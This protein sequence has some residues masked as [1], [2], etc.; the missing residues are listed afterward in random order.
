MH[1]YPRYDIIIKGKRN[2]EIIQRIA[3]SNKSIFRTLVRNVINFVICI[4]F[5]CKITTL[6]LISKLYFSF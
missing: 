1:E 6:F 5:F 3:R 4:K 2:N